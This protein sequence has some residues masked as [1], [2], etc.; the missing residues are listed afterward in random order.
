MMEVWE[1]RDGKAVRGQLLTYGEI[2]D[3]VVR[4]SREFSRELAPGEILV[5]LCLPPGPEF[6]VSDFAL[7]ATGRTPVLIDHLLPPDTL[8]DLLEGFGITAL[9]TSD[10]A[11]TA[12][13]SGTGPFHLLSPALPEPDGEALDPEIL[14]AG[15]LPEGENTVAHLLLTSGTTGEPKGVPLTHR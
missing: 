11:L 9:V 14:L 3:R 8:R 4:K 10:P 6:V 7:M 13:L 2:L 15:M 12:S 5:G 1:E